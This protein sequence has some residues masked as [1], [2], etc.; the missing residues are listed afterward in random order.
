MIRSL[1]FILISVKGRLAGAKFRVALQIIVVAL[2]VSLVVSVRVASRESIKTFDSLATTTSMPWN[3]EIRHVSSEIPLKVLEFL[4]TSTIEKLVFAREDIIES[5]LNKEPIRV[6]TILGGTISDD[7]LDQFSGCTK[8]SNVQFECLNPKIDD[9]ISFDVIVTNTKLAKITLPTV[10]AVFDKNLDSLELKKQDPG[11]LVESYESKSSRANNLTKAYR[12]NL[13]FLLFLSVGLTAFVVFASS[14]HGYKS[15]QATVATMRTVGASKLFCSIF[16]AVES[17]IIG[18]IG[19]LIGLTVLYPLTKAITNLYFV[20]TQA[21]HQTGV[22]LPTFALSIPWDILMGLSCGILAT[23][24]GNILPTLA[25][26]RTKPSLSPRTNE[27]SFVSTRYLIWISL[28]V[29]A[30]GVICYFLAQSI[31]VLNIAYT[32]G[33]VIFIAS[34]CSAVLGLFFISKWLMSTKLANNPA[35]MFGVQSMQAE[36]VRF[37]VAAFAFGVGITFLVSLNIFISSFRTTLTEWMNTTFTADLYIRDE[38]SVLSSKVLSTLKES[39]GLNWIIQTRE[40]DLPLFE[41]RVKTQIIPLQIAIDHKAYQVLSINSQSTKPKLLVSEVLAN[42]NKLSVLD[43]IEIFDRKVQIDGIFKDFSSERGAILLDYDFFITIQPD[44][45]VK[46]V[47]AKFNSTDKAQIALKQIQSLKIPSVVI[48]ESDT[49]RGEALRI[50]DNTFKIT[51]VIQ[52]LVFFVCLIN[53]SLSFLQDIESRQRI[54]GT[55]RL[56]GF[57]L[58]QFTYS[59]FTFGTVILISSSISGL[60]FGNLLGRIIINVINPLS[61]GWNI[62]LAPT[63]LSFTLPILFASISIFLV[64]PLVSYFSLDRIKAAKVTLE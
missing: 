32:S 3:Y 44:I 1:Q 41:T 18:V 29:S 49:L 15:F 60:I 10:I 23:L 2:A 8:K 31:Q 51:W 22:V 56:L 48:F 25:L 50:F 54:Y 58:N 62:T 45:Q 63:A 13:E 57:S 16:V 52:A 43:T 38:S 26:I 33:V 59:L 7:K 30:F 64:I 6:L 35:I 39:P 53:F 14:L 34:G 4:A 5:D 47:N 55:L 17:I 24:L 27:V 20:S 21:H 36:P 40:I 28:V 19:S 42:K 9:N 11:L 61:F 46:S 37:G 12:S